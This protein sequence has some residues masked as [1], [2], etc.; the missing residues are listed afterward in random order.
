MSM[1]RAEFEQWKALER[2]RTVEEMAKAGYVSFP[3]G[4]D[5]PGCPGW[6]AVAIPDDAGPLERQTILGDVI[7]ESVRRFGE[8][9]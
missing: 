6:D 3:C 7:K 5:E 9:T 4:C 8:K 2:G 1:T